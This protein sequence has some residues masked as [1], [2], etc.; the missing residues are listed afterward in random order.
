MYFIAKEKF[1]QH[2]LDGLMQSFPKF[3]VQMR[4]AWYQDLAANTDPTQLI[5]VLN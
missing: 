5:K 4:I 2:K 3:V 1:C